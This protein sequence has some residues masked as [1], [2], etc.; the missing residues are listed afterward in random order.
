[1]PLSSS[2]SAQAKPKRRVKVHLLLQKLGTPQGICPMVYVQHYPLQGEKREH[3]Q[4]RPG[5]VLENYCEP[6]TDPS[7]QLRPCSSTPSVLAQL[8]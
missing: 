2:S 1:M 3:C 5:L 6:T 8:C 4:E 7:K